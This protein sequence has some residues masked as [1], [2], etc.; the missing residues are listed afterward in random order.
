MQSRKAVRRARQS[1]PRAG[2]FFLTVLSALVSLALFVEWAGASYY[3]EF[4]VVLDN[5]FR[6]R[7]KTPTKGR[8]T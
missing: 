7:E 2:C 1:R 5:I 6:V 8:G 3:W 4:Q